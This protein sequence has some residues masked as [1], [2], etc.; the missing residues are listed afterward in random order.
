MPAESKSSTIFMKLMDANARLVV[1]GE[2]GELG[3]EGSIELVSLTFDLDPDRF[4]GGG[5]GGGRGPGRISTVHSASGSKATD[6]VTAR[7]L[8]IMVTGRPVGM[9]AEIVFK[10]AGNEVVPANNMRVNLEDV[11]IS[12]YSPAGGGLVD[13]VTIDSFALNFG[14]STFSQAQLTDQTR[15]VRTRINALSFQDF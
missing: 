3:H 15:P 10:N 5:T 8:E 12:N 13:G 9:K 14:K 6:S 11:V 4:R 7:L 2:V 1:R